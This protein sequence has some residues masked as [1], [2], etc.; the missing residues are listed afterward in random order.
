MPRRIEP[1]MFSTV[2]EAFRKKID[3]LIGTPK[4]TSASNI[5]AVRV[6]RKPGVAGRRMDM[7]ERKK[8]GKN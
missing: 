6:I 4:E 2:N 5:V 8:R 3:L 1:S 7:I